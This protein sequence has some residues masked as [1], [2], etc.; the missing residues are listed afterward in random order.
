MLFGL[1]SLSMNSFWHQLEPHECCSERERESRRGVGVCVCVRERE[2]ERERVRE[3]MWDSDCLCV[4]TG[5]RISGGFMCISTTPSDCWSS[6]GRNIW[7][8]NH[9]ISEEVLA[10]TQTHQQYLFYRSCCVTAL[11]LSR[12]SDK[13]TL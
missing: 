4:G 5:Y 10:T 13:T 12:I 6:L 8:P 3:W 7:Q 9:H 11:L 2:R 1:T